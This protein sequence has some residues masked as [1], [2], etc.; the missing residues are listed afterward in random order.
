MQHKEKDCAYY[1]VDQNEVIKFHHF[2]PG[3]PSQ[4]I[5]KIV[6]WMY[7]VVDACHQERDLV[8]MALSYLHRF[9]CRYAKSHNKKIGIQEFRLLSL[10]CLSIAIKAHGQAKTCARLL[11]KLT[12]EFTQQQIAKCEMLV[13]RVLSF[14]LNPPTPSAFLRVM[15]EVLHI[16]VALQDYAFYIVQLL[17]FDYI[18]NL[19]QYNASTIA[20]ASLRIAMKHGGSLGSIDSFNSTLLVGLIHDELDVVNSLLK[21]E[22]LPW[23]SSM[24]LVLST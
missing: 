3:M 5:Y 21:S 18:G 19:S 16:D 15:F 2:V 13:L 7:N 17:M 24:K 11:R 4:G 20:I 9:V 1:P 6:E 8:E 12:N 14:K 22:E 10:T 23:I